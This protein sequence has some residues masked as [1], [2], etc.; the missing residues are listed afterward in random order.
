MAVDLAEKIIKE[1]IDKD[2]DKTI[3]KFIDGLGD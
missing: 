2:Q 3:D 1:N